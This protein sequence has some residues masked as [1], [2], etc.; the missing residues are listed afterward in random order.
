MMFPYLISLWE[1]HGLG[2]INWKP[3]QPWFKMWSIQQPT[4]LFNNRTL[5]KKM[6]V[7]SFNTTLCSSFKRMKEN[8]VL[9]WKALPNIPSVKN[10]LQERIHIVRSFV[11][12]N[13]FE[14]QYMY[15]LQYAQN[16][17]SRR[18]YKK[19][20]MVV[21]FEKRRLFILYLSVL[22][23]IVYQVHVLLLVFKC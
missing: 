19:P 23:G 7:H 14:M 1:L 20:L 12:I 22:F 3:S 10:K 15:R 13:H 6:L 21:T 9:L 17:L 8:W 11:Y 2:T 4:G 5:V 16:N 18:I